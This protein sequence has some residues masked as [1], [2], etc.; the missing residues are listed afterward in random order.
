MGKIESNLNLGTFIATSVESSKTI[1]E[2]SKCKE[3]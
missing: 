3:G 2:G 1:K